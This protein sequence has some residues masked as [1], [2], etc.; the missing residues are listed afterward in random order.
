MWKLIIGAALIASI[1]A[2]GFIRVDEATWLAW[3]PVWLLGGGST[4]GVGLGLI[5]LAAAERA[6]T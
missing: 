6:S 4:I 2:I 5:A 3:R 1:V